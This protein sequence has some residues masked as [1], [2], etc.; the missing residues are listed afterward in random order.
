[1]DIAVQERT[2]RAVIGLAALE[3]RLIRVVEAAVAA[4]LAVECGILFM[5]V[6]SRY[7]THSPMVWIDELASTLFIWLAMLGA[8]LA[9][10]RGEHMR[11]TTLLLLLSD[12]GRARCEAAAA[13]GVV[14]VVAFLVPPAFEYMQDQVAITKPVLD[15]SD[16]Y[17]AAALPVGLLLMGLCALRQVVARATAPQAAAMV[18]AGVALGLAVWALAD[19][20]A[21]LGNWNLVVFFVV[22][23]GGLILTGVPIAFAFAAATCAYLVTVTDLP[24]SIV[25][26]RLD[27]GMS[28]IVLLSIPLFVLLGHLIVATGLARAMVEFLVALLGRVRGGLSYVLILAMYLVSGI[29]GAKAADMAAVAPILFPEMRKRGA[30]EG[31]LVALLA[32]SGAMAETIPPSIVLIIIGSVAGVSIGS[33][34]VGGLVPALVGALAL[35]AVVFVR[36]RGSTGSDAVRGGRASPS[37]IARAFLVALPALL[38]PVIIRAAVTEGVATATEVST[39]GVVYSL[40]AGLLVYRQIAWT[41]LYPMLVETASLSGAILFVVGT[42]SGMA[43]ALTQSGFAG[44]LA[45]FLTGLGGGRTGFLLVSILMFVLLGSIL[46]GPPALLVFAPLMF[47]IARALGVHDVHYA[48]VVILAMGL[49]LFAPPFGVGYY[50]ACAIGKVSPDRAMRKIW[51]YLAALLFA[52]ILVALVPW[53]SIGFLG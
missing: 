17:R 22:M 36:S 52:L 49:G 10:Q 13:V 48:M 18:V 25:I 35:G 40:A 51:I 24:E 1:M 27:E 4:L 42:A 5:G 6:L 29:S 38:L 12:R 45:A 7:A 30:D 53:L 15:I 28:G 26:S 33:L 11:L 21:E 44:D 50:F 32:A 8:V 39:I 9:L 20:L 23:I 14:A 47:P 43:W 31:E 16:A 34:F 37:A 41:R 46:E 3:R 19:R 2:P